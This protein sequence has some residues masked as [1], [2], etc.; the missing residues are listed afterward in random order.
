MSLIPRYTVG[1][2]RKFTKVKASGAVYTDA[3]PLNRSDTDAT[4]GRM[5]AKYRTKDAAQ[6]VAD[7]LNKWA[8]QEI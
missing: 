7:A 4:V 6:E 5:V 3:Y 8:G 2:Q 1:P